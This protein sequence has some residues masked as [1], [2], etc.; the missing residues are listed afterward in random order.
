MHT[1]GFYIAFGKDAQTISKHTHYKAT[2]K[3]LYGNVFTPCCEVIDFN[4]SYCVKELNENNIDIV[5]MEVD[6]GVV[7]RYFTPTIDEPNEQSVLTFVQP[8]T[9]ETQ[10]LYDILSALKIDDIDLS[11]EGGIL[12]ARDNDYMWSGNEIYKFLIDDVFVFQ[13]DGSILGISDTLL[14]DFK[15][16]VKKIRLNSLITDTRHFIVVILLKKLKI[17]T[18][19]CYIR[20]E[21]S[22]KHLMMMQKL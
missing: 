14:D 21:I 19:F 17:L 6:K 1:G 2:G 16:F 9:K 7:E 10:V 8:E 11:Y 3:N 4:L 5:V 20:L 13:D 22:L 12:V 18:S 15:S